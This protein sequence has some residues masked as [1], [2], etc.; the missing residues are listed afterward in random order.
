VSLS[1]DPIEHRYTWNGRRVPSVTQCL[2]PLFD[3]SA[4]PPAVLKR[5]QQIGT[6]VHAAIH[7]ELSGG[8]DHTSIDPACR[9]YFDAWLRFREE[10]V[11]EPVLVEYRV[12]NDE[13]GEALRY[14]GTLDEWGYLG[15]Y[16]G[17]IDWK[18]T[19]VLNVPAVGAQTAAYLKALARSGIGALSDRRFAL[20]LGSDGRY[21]LERFRSIDNDWRTFVGYL[22]AARE[23]DASGPD[24]RALRV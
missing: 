20:K 16:P 6:A 22:R 10:C 4:V 14:A 12:T 7:L 3:F 5:K 1:F 15:G 23:A 17:L 11:F 19:M 21:K 13:L 18:T 24:V 9:P 8:V 2:E